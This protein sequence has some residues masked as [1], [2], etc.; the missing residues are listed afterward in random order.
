MLPSALNH[1][2]F[3]LLMIGYVLAAST[4]VF[5][6]PAFSGPN[7]PLHYEYIALL[8]RTGRLPDPATSVRADERHQ[9]PIYYT[10]AALASLLFADPALDSEFPQNPH[11]TSTLYG[12]LNPFV[13]VTPANAPVLYTS[14][15]VSVLFG[16]LAA[17]SIYSAARQTLAPTTCLLVLSLTVFQPTFLHLSATV[18]ND[19]PA[20]AVGAALVAYTTH[21]V[22]RNKEPRAFFSWGLLFAAAMLTKANTVFLALMLPAACWA[23]WRRKGH[24]RPGV[25]CGLW[26]LAGFIPLWAGWLA[27]NQFRTGDALG[28]AASVPVGR[29][30]SLTPGDLALLLPH[31]GELFRSFWLDWSPG[32]LGYAPDWVYVWSGIALLLLASG[33]VR[34][35]RKAS[36]PRIVPWL[37]LLW[38]F[39]LCATYLSVK[40]L[41]IRELG[42]VVPEGRWMLPAVPSLAWLIAVG[43]SRWWRPQDQ[44][45]ACSLATL[46]PIASTGLLL[47]LFLPTLFPRATRLASVNHIPEN[48][49]PPCLVYGE[50]LALLA[51]ESEPFV[52][53][54]QSPVTLYWQ[55]LRAPLHNHTVSLQLLVPRKDGWVK[56]AVQNSYPGHGLS[57]TR[58]WRPGD[59]FRDQV[60]LQ[61][62]GDLD[63]PTHAVLG[64]WLLTEQSVEPGKCAG[65]AVDYPIIAQVVVRPALPVQSPSQDHRL[66]AP[67]SFGGILDLT[68]LAYSSKGDELV[69][70]LWWAASVDVPTDY[71][72]YVH[73]L[74]KDNQ[75]IAQS[76]SPP[77]GGSS[78][79]RIW[80]AGDLVRDQHEMQIKPPPDSVLLV[81]VYD[82]VTL[83]RL[84]ASQDGQALSNDA[85]RQ[86]LR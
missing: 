73:V 66:A 85:W 25:Q 28:L 55:A 15:L 80:R 78:P 68:A 48:S 21:L 17:L 56:L 19:L 18:N 29:L 35:A 71:T 8:R 9:P 76:D 10:V 30:A 6:L 33:W 47:T 57:P 16:V 26:G 46:A 79:T 41:M 11:Y 64:L 72:V 62:D 31:A 69:V 44:R 74:D 3:L 38:A 24:L 20:T 39:G 1:R 63:G 49:Q 59:L 4:L 22:V 81:G 77:A 51:A 32:R 23:K 70:T 54:Q 84:P 27:L 83:Q 65:Q 13:E 45:R 61:P 60:T 53:G 5:Y 43:W 86:S 50:E 2:F 36:R 67:A 34:R 58:A 42:F 75:L 37:H 7:E 40:S 82:S 14:R 52:I 12:N